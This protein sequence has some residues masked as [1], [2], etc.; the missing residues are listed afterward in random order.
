MAQDEKRFEHNSL[1]LEE[2]SD[3]VYVTWGARFSPSHDGAQIMFYYMSY[4][5]LGL[6]PAIMVHKKS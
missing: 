4:G 6:A 3:K 1:T 2:R 5:A